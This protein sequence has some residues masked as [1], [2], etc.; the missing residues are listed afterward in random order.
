MG[1]GFMKSEFSLLLLFIGLAT[2]AQASN[3]NTT[4]NLI[5]QGIEPATPPATILDGVPLMEGLQLATEKDLLTMLP[6]FGG[7]Q[8]TVTVGIVDVD[9]LYDFYKRVLPPLGWQAVTGY[10]YVRGKESLNL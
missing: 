3:L 2:T 7:P 6:D 9:D 1:I 8:P 5:N 4:S 10:S